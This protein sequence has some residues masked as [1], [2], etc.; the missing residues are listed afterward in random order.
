MFIILELSNPMQI[1][2]G[3]PSGFVVYPFNFSC[4]FEMLKLKK[5]RNLKI[6][7]KFNICALQVYQDLLTSSVAGC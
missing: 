7:S 2:D 3:Y 5:N 1:N 4:I 6:P